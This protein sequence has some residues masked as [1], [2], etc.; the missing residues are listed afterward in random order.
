LLISD[1]TTNQKHRAML[2]LIYACGLRRSELLNLGTE[3]LDSKRGSFIIKDAKGRKARLKPMNKVIEILRE[4]YSTY[5]Q[6]QW[7]F[8]GQFPDTQ[9]NARSLEQVLKN[10]FKTRVHL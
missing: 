7:L 4:Y 3:H 8:E 5:K 9:Y 1:Y 10:A 2:S 6:K